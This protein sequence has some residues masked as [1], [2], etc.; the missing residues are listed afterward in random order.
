MTEEVLYISDNDWQIAKKLA[1]AIMSNP[2]DKMIIC[3]S[4]AS[5]SG[6]SVLSYCLAKTIANL[7]H[8]VKILHLDDFYAITP[9]ERKTWRKKHG[10]EKIGINEYDWQQIEEVSL[11]FKNGEVATIPSVDLINHLVDRLTIDFKHANILI[12]EG[13][14]AIHHPFSDLNIFIETHT[15]NILSAQVLRKKENLDDF[16]QKVIERESE[17]V[18]S[19]KKNADMIINK[20]FNQIY[21][22]S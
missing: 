5:G 18:E 16:R 9:K 1:N 3:V 2:K 20:D 14:Y 10:I 7:H 22:L 6:K 4:G 19:L 17:V 13:L 15:E 8:I 12:I 21:K 11:Q